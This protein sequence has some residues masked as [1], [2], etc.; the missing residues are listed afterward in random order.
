M[1]VS[2]IRAL[3]ASLHQRRGG[4]LVLIACKLQQ[5][6]QDPPPDEEVDREDLADL[7]DSFSFSEIRKRSLQSRFCSALCETTSDQDTLLNFGGVV[8]PF[9]PMSLFVTFAPSMDDTLRT[10]LT[11]E[12]RI[13]PRSHKALFYQGGLVLSVSSSIPLTP[14][15]LF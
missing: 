14:S 8:L 9:G 5:L 7:V 3:R 2:V 1:M 11:K 4:M 15:A 10:S 13:A 12:V 6:L